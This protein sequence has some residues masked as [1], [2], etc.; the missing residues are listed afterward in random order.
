M[1]LIGEAAV[2]ANCERLVDL[3]AWPPATVNVD[4]WLSNFSDGERPFAAHLLNNF[5]FFSNRTVDALFRAAFH[6]VSNSLRA[7]WP[8]FGAGAKIWNGFLNEVIVTFSQGEIA[9]PTDSGHAYARA[10]R[11][12]FD[13]PQ[14]RVMNPDQALAAILRGFRGPVV[15]VDDF[16]G[17]GEQFV[18]TWKR[19]RKLDGL[20][21]HS[22]AELATLTPPSDNHIFYCTAMMTE[23]GYTRLGRE[24]P[25]VLL[26]TGNVIPENFSLVAADSVMWPDG[27]RQDGVNFI[28]DVSKR[29]GLP[30]DGGETDWRGFNRLGL[31]LAFEDSTPDA[32]IPLFHWS[33]RW[34]PLVRRS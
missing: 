10:A 21:I 19:S 3:H 12:L 34:T 9:N 5:M 8:P 2:I 13:I 29:I 25:T 14:T 4:G 18:A 31:G 27:S 33:N 30:S 28:R 23:R 7:G 20:G 1:G 26:S 17:S 32:T 11:K 24:C 15:F 16:V 6:G 22:F